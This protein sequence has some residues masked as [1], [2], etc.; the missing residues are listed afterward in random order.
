M[1]IGVTS[2]H[3]SRSWYNANASDTAYGNW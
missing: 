3:Q 1:R 2:S